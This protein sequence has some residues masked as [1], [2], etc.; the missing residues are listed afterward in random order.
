MFR[1]IL[2]FVFGV[3]GGKLIEDNL[4]NLNYKSL[5]IGFNKHFV[6]FLI[7]SYLGFLYL[8]TKV[9]RSKEAQKNYIE[10]LIALAT[11]ISIEEKEKKSKLLNS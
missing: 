2:L 8:M 6:P 7:M 5:L 1:D 10:L 3:F 9:D 11:V 4:P